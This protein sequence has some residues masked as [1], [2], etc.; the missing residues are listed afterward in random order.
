MATPC[1]T[2]RSTRWHAGARRRWS[3]PALAYPVFGGHIRGSRVPDT[4][5]PDVVLRIGLTGGIGSGKSMVSRLLATYGAVVVDSDVIAR[6]VVAP[7]TAGLAAVVAEF[8]T[9]VLQPD[10]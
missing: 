8:G 5:G 9:A 2:C 6:E 3:P 4:D 7:G 1:V 10:G